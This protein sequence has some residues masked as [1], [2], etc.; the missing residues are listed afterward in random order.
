[1][2][3]VVE[4]TVEADFTFATT[5]PFAL[6]RGGRL[7]PVT[8]HYAIYGDL[9][10]NRERV[11]LVGH[12]L[13]GSARVADWWPD[14]F[15][16][17]GPFNLDHYC[18]LGINI[19]GSC[20][21]STGPKSFNPATEK[22]YGPDF[23]LV[24]IGDI[25]RTQALL[26]DH[27]RIPRLLAVIGA[28]I[29][30]MQALDWALRFPER[31]ERSIVI[32]TAPL[33]A[34]GLALNHLQR[35]SIG[36]DP[37]W[38]NGWYDEQPAKGLGAARALAMLSY[39]SAEL[40]EERYGRKPNRNG[41]DP[42]STLAGRFDVA[43]YLDHQQEVFVKRFDA[44]T[45]ITISKFMDA[46]DVP[47]EGAPPY[48]AMVKNHVEVEVVGIS[49]DWLFPPAD[50]EQLHQRLT[51]EGVLSRYSELASNHGHDAFLADPEHLF[52]IIRN[53][54]ASRKRLSK[55]AIGHVHAG[56]AD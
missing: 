28:S 40:F 33:G 32:G 43:G 39:K 31:V 16:A 2:V 1:M 18:V 5:E 4:P 34:L 23:P 17:D 45:Y 29:G 44:N 24:T 55:A 52:P 27:L 21:G 6:E 8:L 11:I 13:S 37:A 41:E 42:F 3:Q 9:E 22:Q 49:S 38:K 7:G 26:L 51:R 46:W 15:G 30:G 47:P 56:A 20:Y 12:A 10:R 50:V 48:R 53:S 54:L 36:N 14:L 25:V 35:L 19:L